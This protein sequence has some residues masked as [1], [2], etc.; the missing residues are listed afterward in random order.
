MNNNNNK[1]NQGQKIKSTKPL[2]MSHFT[3]GGQPQTK[4][5]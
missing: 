3:E 2:E 1:K 4:Q 5:S